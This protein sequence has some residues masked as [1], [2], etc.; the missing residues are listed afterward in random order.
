MAFPAGVPH[1]TIT[2]GPLS[3]QSGD[4][5]Y[6]GTIYITPSSPCVH[7][8]TGTPFTDS[9]IPCVME[10]GLATIDLLPS[11]AADVTVLNRT[12]TFD[13]T[14][15]TDPL[16]QPVG[17]TARDVFIPATATSIDY[18]LLL[19]SSHGPQVILFPTVMTLL[20]MTGA[21]AGAD[22]AAALWPYLQGTADAR[23][24]TKALADSTFE[25][26][27]AGGAAAVAAA[28]TALK[29]ETDPFPQYMTQTEADA[30]YPILTGG[31]ISTSVLP[32][33]AVSDTFVVSSQAAMLALGSSGANTG[34]VA[35]R[36]DTNTSFILGGTGDPAVLGNW[37]VI[38][39]PGSG[40]SSVNGQTGSVSLTAV[41]LGAVINI[42]GK[43][44]NGAGRVDLIP[45]DLG[46]A[47]ENSWTYYVPADYTGTTS[48][49]SIITAAITAINA[50]MSSLVSL[51]VH[52]VAMQFG[53]GIVK[54]TTA[55]LF[56]GLLVGGGSSVRAVC[57]RG[58]GYMGKR[59]TQLLFSSTQGATLDQSQGCLFRI[60]NA[61]QVW[62]ENFHI[63][64]TNANQTLWYLHC[65]ASPGDSV[66]HTEWANTGGNNSMR[67]RNIFL[68][69][70]WKTIWGADGGVTANQNSECVFEGFT[71][72]NSMT[73]SDCLFRF[74]YPLYSAVFIS[75]NSSTPTAGTWTFTLNGITSAAIAYNATAAT[76]EA[77]VA[78]MS[79]VGTG[80]VKVTGQGTSKWVIEFIST[81]RGIDTTNT[82]VAN[83]GVTPVSFKCYRYTPQQSQFLNYVW[84]DN[85]FEYGSGNLSVMNM[86]GFHRFEGYCSVILGING[87]GGFVFVMDDI[88]GRSNDSKSLNADNVRVE[89]RNDLC[90]VM[91][92]GWTDINSFVTLRHFGIADNN[93]SDKT[94]HKVIEINNGGSGAMPFVHITDCDFPGYMQV[95]MAAAASGGRLVLERVRFRNYTTPSMAISGTNAIRVT[96][97]CR[98]RCIDVKGTGG[99]DFAGLSADGT[100]TV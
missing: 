20:G 84:R 61:R 14:D 74:G 47:A 94:N 24:Y 100:Q 48:S 92:L 72:S 79:N 4:S 22:L 9:R 10:N 59:A 69:G 13:F 25:F 8:P 87:G 18:D 88:P 23:Y 11:D 42:N 99:N 32:S 21:I 68:D 82:S 98:L 56:D 39:S 90:G 97:G 2:I 51:N 19:P 78:A 49:D 46:I 1:V 26:K 3:T 63:K 7:I 27:G 95:N 73:V 5:N 65:N 89:L 38:S 77:A 96:G 31:K 93:V 34:D 64:S 91:K 80:N 50:K 16:G 36:T 15:V 44:P 45:S 35:V 37:I 62:F 55:A 85:E 33:L 54:I 6:N 83:T 29:A 76:V 12:Y 75:T 86:G 41:G 52:T 71:C 60:V 57:V 40:V 58:W 30:R 66:T 70:T 43:T 53:P 67:F 81:L 28:I 17:L